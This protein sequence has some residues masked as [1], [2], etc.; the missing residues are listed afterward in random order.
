M[1]KILVIDDD[2]VF[3]DIAKAALGGAGHKVEEAGDGKTGVEAFRKGAFDL[4]IV[5][6]YMPGQDGIDT[7]FDLD[8]GAKG[9]A[10]IA[11]T[12]GHSMGK[13][14]LQLATSAGADLAMEK[15]FTPEELVKAVAGLLAKMAKKP[16]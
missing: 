14:S 11:V 10:V 4:V 3:R 1:A 12:G 15:D 16:K 7:I 5:D 6:M 13:D 2:A 8:A 9:A